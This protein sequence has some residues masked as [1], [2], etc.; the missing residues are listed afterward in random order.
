MEISYKTHRDAQFSEKYFSFQAFWQ[1]S[2]ISPT[3]LYRNKPILFIAAMKGDRFYFCPEKSICTGQA[4]C[5]LHR[6]LGIFCKTTSVKI[7]ILCK[8]DG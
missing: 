5:A 1:G 8:I 4:V 2:T 3:F 6:Q 7:T